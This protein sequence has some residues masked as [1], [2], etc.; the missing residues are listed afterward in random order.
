MKI[1]CYSIFFIL[2]SSTWAPSQPVTVLQSYDYKDPA[3]GFVHPLD[4]LLDNRAV[5]QGQGHLVPAEPAG[6]TR[7]KNDSL[8]SLHGR[9]APF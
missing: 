1:I 8:D 9:V 7:G 6:Q 3:R 5:S 2:I 4:A